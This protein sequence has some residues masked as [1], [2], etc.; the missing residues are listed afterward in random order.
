M[1]AHTTILLINAIALWALLATVDWS[2]R[3]L[4][5]NVSLPKGVQ[6]F[7]LA[8]MGA[9]GFW[10]INYSLRTGCNFNNTFLYACTTS[11]EGKVD[12]RGWLST[13]LGLVHQLSFMIAGM[14]LLANEFRIHPGL[15][16]E[17]GHGSLSQKMRRLLI[18]SPVQK[19]VFVS[20]VVIGSL[21]I[22]LNI[23]HAS[24]PFN[25]PSTFVSQSLGSGV[26]F[27]SFGLIAFA[28]DWELN[29]HQRDPFSTTIVGSIFIYGIIQLFIP[30]G[31]VLANS[32]FQDSHDASDW[33]ELDWLTPL[34]MVSLTAKITMGLSVMALPALVSAFLRNVQERNQL[35]TEL[36]IWQTS[37]K[38]ELRLKFGAAYRALDQAE[39][40]LKKGSS[41][42]VIEGKVL[43]AKQ[44]VQEGLAFLRSHPDR[45][46]KYEKTDMFDLVKTVHACIGV[47]HERSD[48]VIH[49]EMPTECIVQ[50]VHAVAVQAIQRFMEN[51]ISAN[52][53]AVTLLMTPKGGFVTLD[54]VDDGTGVPEAK[55]EHLFLRNDHGLAAARYALSIIGADAYL[56]ESRPGHTKFCITFFKGESV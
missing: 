42:D 53:H 37:T 46:P 33:F 15:P 49:V 7:F 51:A 48:V 5:R 40:L 4:K 52:A 23:E 24:D 55:R 9:L 18:S 1:N 26:D 43:S 16:T 45:L 13:S 38:H 50:G 6:D 35:Q 14:Y 30:L 17:C 10:A 11:P 20:V 19:L 41:F 8:F 12:V 31:I 34:R 36:L 47:W 25:A 56:A 27:I 54:I 22:Y 2:R 28:L 44:V 29:F 32:N 39:N 3:Q 21:N